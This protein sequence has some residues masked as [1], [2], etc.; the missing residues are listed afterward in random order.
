MTDEPDTA[1][2]ATPTEDPG[3]DTLT[4]TFD[5]H[6]YVV[7]ANPNDLPALYFE[8]LQGGPQENFPMA[9]R[10]MLGSAQ[11]GAWLA[12]GPKGRDFMRLFGA[13]AAAVGVPQGESSASTD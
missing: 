12:T 5:N 13:Y 7:A 1:K 10:A 6:E 2:T 4:F 8:G 9:A 3:V 11:Y